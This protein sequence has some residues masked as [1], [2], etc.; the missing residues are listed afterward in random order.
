MLLQCIHKTYKYRLYRNNKVD[1]LIH[2]QINVAGMIW[3]HALTLQKR[4]YKLTRK[5]IPLY[6]MQKHIAK[7]RMHTTQY[8][9]WKALGSQAVQEILERLDEA[10]QR[11]FKKQSGFPR[12]KKVKKFKSFILKQAGW[13]LLDKQEG[14]K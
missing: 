6:V 3:N 8:A 2:H 5:Y 14:K 9:Y 1:G 10:Y 4:Y 12:F 11:F 13:D 7:L